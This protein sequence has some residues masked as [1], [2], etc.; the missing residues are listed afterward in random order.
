MS[1]RTIYFL[2]FNVE[3]IVTSKKENHLIPKYEII[4]LLFCIIVFRIP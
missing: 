3:F 4:L 2:Y 1:F